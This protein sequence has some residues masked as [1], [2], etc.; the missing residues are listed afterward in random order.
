MVYFIVPQTFPYFN[1]GETPGV[2]TNHVNPNEEISLPIEV[3][4]PYGNI[5][6]SRL[7]VCFVQEIICAYLLAYMN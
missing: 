6:E 1:L 2:D 4:F 3:S 7:Y 5:L